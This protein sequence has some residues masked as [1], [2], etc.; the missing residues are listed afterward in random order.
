MFEVFALY[1]GELSCYQSFINYHQFKS[2]SGTKIR[3]IG[4]NN[5]INID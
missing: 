1:S 2:C 3:T 4:T 5:E